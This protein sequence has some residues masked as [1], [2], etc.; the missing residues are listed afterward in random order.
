MYNTLFEFFSDEMNSRVIGNA[1]AIA[2]TVGLVIPALVAAAT[3]VSRSRKRASDEVL[4][5]FAAW[6]SP[7]RA[8]VRKEARRAIL[9]NQE[10]G[11]GFDRLMQDD[12]LWPTII[13]FL[14]DF[15]FLSAFILSEGA[16]SYRHR[17]AERYLASTV[18]SSWDATNTL[19]WH[20]RERYNEPILFEEF[21]RLAKTWR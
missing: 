2:Q 10:E 1:T 5:F 16:N 13:Q 17:M 18:L 8:A 15:E 3:Y 20:L 6:N 11:T 4:E 9:S 19:V 21:E 14:N 12:T 7:E